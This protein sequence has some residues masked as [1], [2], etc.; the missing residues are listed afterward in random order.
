[1]E[2]GVA[3]TALARH[4]CMSEFYQVRLARINPPLEITLRSHNCDHIPG[5]HNLVRTVQPVQGLRLDL[6]DI[7]ATHRIVPMMPSPVP[8]LPSERD[9]AVSAMTWARGG[10][11]SLVPQSAHARTALREEQS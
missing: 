3:S 4:F 8:L 1:M 5:R 11:P 6:L 2:E 10:M 7:E 9:C